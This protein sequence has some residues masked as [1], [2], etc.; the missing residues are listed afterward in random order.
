LGQGVT[1][2]AVGDLVVSENNPYACGQCRVCTTGFPNLCR[3]KRAMGIHSDGCFAAYL[4]LP[5]HLLHRV[6]PGVSAEVAALAE[7]LAVATHAVADRCGIAPGDTVVVL[8]PGAIGLLAAQVARAE[9]AARVIVA[10]TAQDEGL[11]FGVAHELGLETCNVQREKL[12][13]RVLAV[14]GGLG[15]DVVVEAAGAPAAVRQAITLLR[16]AGRLVVIGLT[17]KPELAVDWDGMI[18]KGLRVDFSYSSRRPNWDKAMHYLAS[19][20]VR[21][22]PLITA[23]RPLTEWPEAFAALERQETLRTIF[24]LGD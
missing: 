11:R 17:G 22:L 15:A 3:S 9:G 13:E 5:E 21:T 18:G 20:Q 2:V 10:G 14:T 24:T 6:P 8:G 12:E 19:G 16:R 1:A 23:R 4:K 7:P